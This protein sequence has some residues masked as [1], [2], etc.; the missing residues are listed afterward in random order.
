[1]KSVSAIP[2]LTIDGP[3][4]SGK[5]TIARKVAQ[6]LGWHLL[7]SG[8][9]YRLVG[10]S[11]LQQGIADNAESELADLA[12]SMNVR[13][14]SDDNDDERIWL[15]SVDVTR[16]IRTEESGLMAS[17]V[18]LLP[19][20][21]M[22]L[23]GLQKVFRKA[24]GLVADGRDMGTRIFPDACLKVFLTATAE[25][26]AKRRHK[27]L[28]DKGIDVSLPA[29][30]RDI[31]DRDRRDSERSIAP[32]RPA[33]DARVLDSSKLTIDEVTQMVLVWARE[34]VGKSQ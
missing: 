20:V 30:A 2:V 33:D 6:E 12:A 16:D 19:A 18:A 7:D 24:P 22:A 34:C 5:G 8:A 14:D 9:L 25:E 17:K 15:G 26:R 28:K 4:G 1:M 11:A 29:L 27:Q 31:E 13:F 23:V 32:L 21:R 10:L 3:S